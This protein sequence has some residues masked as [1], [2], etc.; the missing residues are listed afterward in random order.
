VKGGV[1][2]I[3]LNERDSVGVNELLLVSDTDIVLVRDIV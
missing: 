3:G 2:G 1:V